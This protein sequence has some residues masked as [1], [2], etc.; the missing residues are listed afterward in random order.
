MRQVGT[1]REYNAVLSSAGCRLESFV[2]AHWEIGRESV[3]ADIYVRFAAYNDF[4]A[5][6][7]AIVVVK[8]VVAVHLDIVDACCRVGLCVRSLEVKSVVA[9]SS[10]IGATHKLRAV[11]R[12]FRYENVNAVVESDDVVVG[13]ACAAVECAVVGVECGREVGRACCS[14]DYQLVAFGGDKA[15]WHFL[16]VASTKVGSVNAACAC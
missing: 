1:E 14:H 6:A 13:N 10:D 7:V 12:K 15:V 8:R 16:S 9:G 2:Y 3:C 5:C 4:S 11:F